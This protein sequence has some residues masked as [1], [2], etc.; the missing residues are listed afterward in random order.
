MRNA[1]ELPYFCCRIGT[2]V[3][4]QLAYHLVQPNLE[5][6]IYLHIVAV[7]TVWQVNNII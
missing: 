5:A 2:V 1:T 7:N 3:C 4:D 6:N